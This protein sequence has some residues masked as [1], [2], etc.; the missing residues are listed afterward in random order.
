MSFNLAF[1]RKLNDMTS[2]N[3]I[4]N[5]ERETLILAGVIISLLG[6]W[7]AYHQYREQKEI[8]ALQKQIHQHEL[9]QINQDKANG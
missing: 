6:L 1:R 2:V 5:I 9:D 4:V 3:K 8:N 7:L